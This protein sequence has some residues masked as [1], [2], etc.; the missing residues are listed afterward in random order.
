MKVFFSFFFFLK[1]CYVFGNRSIKEDGTNLNNYESQQNTQNI[2]YN[3]IPLQKLMF[4]HWPE[5]TFQQ[6]RVLTIKG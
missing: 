2:T 6:L 1:F 5:R 3:R 4:A